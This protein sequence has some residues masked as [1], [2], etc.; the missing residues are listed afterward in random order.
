MK[1]IEIEGKLYEPF[2]WQKP[3]DTD[4]PIGEICF[5]IY[6]A[7]YGDGPYLIVANGDKT[8]EPFNFRFKEEVV[9]PLFVLPMPGI[10]MHG[11]MEVSRNEAR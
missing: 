10:G 5:G 11:L 7:Q 8:F 4:Y 6:A 1:T 9:Q 3:E 2:E